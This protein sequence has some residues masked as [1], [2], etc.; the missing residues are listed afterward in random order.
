MTKYLLLAASFA[1]CEIVSAQTNPVASFVSTSPCLGY[2]TSFIDGSVSGT[3][4]PVTSWKWIIP[5]ANPSASTLENP[6]A[7][8]SLSGTYTVTLIVTSQ[9]GHKDSISKQVIVHAIPVANFMG[10]GSG[11][12]PVCVTN[13]TDLSTSN[14]GE[15]IISWNWTF[16]GG[17]PS[18]ST[19]ANPSNICYDSVGSYGAS[20]TV[21]SVSGCKDTIAFSPVV[22][23]YALP[24]ASFTYSVTSNTV[25]CTNTSSSIVT[26][27]AW[28]F[29]DGTPVDTNKSPNH[30]YVYGNTY[31]ICLS[32]RSIFGCTD[33]LCKAILISS[34]EENYLES[35]ITISPNPF[36]Y[37]ATLH[38]GKNFKSGRLIVYNA[39]G[40][41]VK[42]LENI[43]GHSIVLQRDNLPKGLYFIRLTQDNK[44][45]ATKKTIIE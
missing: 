36:S 38:T 22:Q 12:I 6:V 28:N 7:T 35:S 16:Q 13:F 37:A 26:Q 8:Y 33:S 5:G 10:S 43:S 23:V 39:L 3:G 24:T 19:Q 11:C 20:L 41:E 15:N 27:S 31:N 4:D 44:I 1:L 45:I 29:G 18:S 30:T 40:Q 34:V 17:T 14:T 2:A 42:R 9:A 21:T 25:S 32:V